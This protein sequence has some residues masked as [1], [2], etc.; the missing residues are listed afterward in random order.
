MVSRHNGQIARLISLILIVIPLF[1]GKLYSEKISLEEVPPPSLELIYKIRTTAPDKIVRNTLSRFIALYYEPSMTVTM[2]VRV[3]SSGGPAIAYKTGTLRL[4]RLKDA[5]VSSG[6][7]IS[8]IIKS[9]VIVSPESELYMADSAEVK[10][11]NDTERA[12]LYSREISAEALKHRS[13][14]TRLIPEWNGKEADSLPVFPPGPLKQPLGLTI[15]LVVIYL[16]LGTLF[17]WIQYHVWLES[18]LKKHLITP[19]VAVKLERMIQESRARALLSGF[20]HKIELDGDVP[21]PPWVAEKPSKE[22]EIIKPSVEETESEKAGLEKQEDLQWTPVIHLYPYKNQNTGDS[23]M[24]DKID[25]DQATKTKGLDS[26]LSRDFQGMSIQ[27]LMKS[28]IHALKGL[29]SRHTRMLE[30]GFGVATI[31]DL[32]NL[33]YFEIA[34][35]IA[36]LAQHEKDQM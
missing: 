12:L 30:E 23:K 16:L 2:V 25:Q 1:S 18:K 5:V 28:P 7:P 19:E 6:I 8:S 21:Y 29:E 11:F 13:T 15:Y 33:K 20:F 17:I 27:D 9:P 24:T 22:S 10:F 4:E 32:A 34:R 26:L 14:W 36:I 31:E 3:S 35:A